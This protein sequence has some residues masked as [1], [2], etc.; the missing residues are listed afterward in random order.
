MCTGDDLIKQQNPLNAHPD[1]ITDTI[2]SIY[3][4][5]ATFT[6]ID[7]LEYTVCVTHLHTCD[8]HWMTK[9]I[10]THQTSYV[11]CFS[12]KGSGD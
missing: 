12:V 2:V 3:Q 1:S 6:G 5:N 8:V 7:T 10:G 11:G 4:N 9:Q